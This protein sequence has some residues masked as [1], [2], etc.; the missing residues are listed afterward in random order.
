MPDVKQSARHRVGDKVRL[1][2]GT[3][4]TGTV[5]EVRQ[6]YSPRGHTMYRVRIPMSPEPL[7]IEAREDEVEKA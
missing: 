7:W 1:T 4:L 2:F 5:T 3:R 6:A